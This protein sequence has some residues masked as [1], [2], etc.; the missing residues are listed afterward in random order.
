MRYVLDRLGRHRP[1]PVLGL[2]LFGT[3]TTGTDLIK[4]A[5]SVGFVLQFTAARPLAWATGFV[6]K[7]HRQL[8]QLASASDFLNRLYDQWSL[9]VVNGG[10]P[11]LRQDERAWLPVRV[12]TAEQDYFVSESSA[13]SFYGEVDWH[14]LAFSH[15]ALVKPDSRDDVRYQRARDFLKTCRRAKDGRVLGKIW[16]M[17][18]AVWNYHSG[19]LIK[20]WRYVVNIHKQG[21]TAMGPILKD[22]GFSPCSVECSY[23]TVLEQSD[24]RI[25]V[26]LGKIAGNEFWSKMRAAEAGSSHPAYAHGFYVDTLPEIE[27]RKVTDELIRILSRKDTEASWRLLFRTISVALSTAGDTA[28]IR[29][30]EGELFRGSSALLRSFTLP[31][32]PS[33]IGEE[34]TIKINYESIVPQALP[35]FEV[36]FPWLT[37]GCSL[38]IIVHGDME[39]FVWASHLVGEPMTEVA[40]ENQGQLCKFMFKCNDLVLP[41]S[42]L[43]IRWQLRAKTS[44]EGKR[45]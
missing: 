24:I 39:Y 32:T 27:R 36:R 12:V 6:L 19:K 26:S 17:S 20:D 4:L 5:Q 43:D 37:Q 2:L 41:A 22:S 7:R 38:E 34:V 11:S 10:D 28:D 13:K 23:S 9:R 25:G 3:P 18:Q 45:K 15:T 40:S 30:V 21:E 8:Q 35:S 33:V 16:E 29:L 44:V 42:G 1:F 14:P 31:S